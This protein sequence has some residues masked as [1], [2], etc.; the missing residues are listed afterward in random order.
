MICPE[1][2]FNDERQ[3]DAQVE[4]NDVDKEDRPRKNDASYCD[5]CRSYSNLLF[6]FPFARREGRDCGWGGGTSESRERRRENNKQRLVA[7]TRV[8]VQLTGLGLSTVQVVHFVNGA[9]RWAESWRLLPPMAEPDRF[10]FF[11]SLQHMK[12][13]KTKPNKM[14]VETNW[15]LESKWLFFFLVFPLISYVGIISRNP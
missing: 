10:C 15:T 13:T 14:I 3:S 7:C 6:S 1:I 2:V 11:L 8:G 5:H 9:S 4:E 12:M